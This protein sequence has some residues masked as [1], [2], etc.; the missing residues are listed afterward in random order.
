MT[1]PGSSANRL[2]DIEVL[3][4]VCP[5]EFDVTRYKDIAFHNKALPRIHCFIGGAPIPTLP[6]IML[7]VRRKPLN[8]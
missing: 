8:G 4:T 2:I 7:I 6:S 5:G 3:G 1:I